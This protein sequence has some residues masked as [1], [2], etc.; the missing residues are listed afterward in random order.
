MKVLIIGAPGVGKT[1]LLKKLTKTL[2]SEE[3]QFDHLY[4]SLIE[5]TDNLNE[6]DF[7]DFVARIFIA[8]MNTIIS[9]YND[10]RC[11]FEFPYYDYSILEQLDL[12]RFQ[13]IICLDASLEVLLDRNKQRNVN[14]KIPEDYIK[15]ANLSL[16]EFAEDKRLKIFKTDNQNAQ[17]LFT[18]IITYYF[19]K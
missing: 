19:D 15:K 18:S 3:F 9:L 10:T 5:S 17:N 13:A 16:K 4:D 1:T 2:N 12:S 6:Y 8:K 7:V 14:Q 11:I